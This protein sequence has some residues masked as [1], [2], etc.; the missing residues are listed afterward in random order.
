[1]SELRVVVVA[2]AVSAV[3]AGAAVATASGPPPPEPTPPGVRTVVAHG[4]GTVEVAKP[5]RRTDASIE[6]VAALARR[7]A[8]P[9]AVEAARA[10]AIRV[11]RAAGL[12]L[13]K[14]IGVERDLAPYG[15]GDASEGTNGPGQW[16]WE[17]RGRRR[18]HVPRTISVRVTL[19]I[20][21]S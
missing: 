21:A 17:H 14:P 16:C 12:A 7:A 15:Y 20:A 3:V 18:C 6:R 13:G 2:A 19:T 8:L 10:D 1:M 9:K 5:L 4:T 11:A